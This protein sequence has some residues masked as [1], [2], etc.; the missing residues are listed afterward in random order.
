MEKVKLP[1]KNS[2][3]KKTEK[4]QKDLTVRYQILLIQS[5][6]PNHAPKIPAHLLWVP[7]LQAEPW[8]IDQIVSYLNQQQKQQSEK[9]PTDLQEH[10]P[11]SRSPKS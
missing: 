5:H 6:F 9:L 8:Q 1:C 3:T 7:E 10:T 2:S 4:K 11:K